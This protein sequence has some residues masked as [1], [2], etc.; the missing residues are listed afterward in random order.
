MPRLS[1]TGRV[2]MGIAGI[3]GSVDSVLIPNSRGG[4]WLDP[5]HIVFIHPSDVG[6]ILYNTI[7]KDRVP[8]SGNAANDLFAGGGQWA[9]WLAGF[10]MYTSTGLVLPNAG[11]LAV[12][13]DGAIGYVPNRNLDNGCHIL[14]VD[15]SQNW[16]LTSVPVAEVQLL[17]SKRAIWRDFN[18]KFSV[19]NLPDVIT[20]AGMKWH[21][22]AVFIDDEWWV[23]YLSAIYGLVL[24]PFNST[25]G[26]II[27]PYSDS[28][29]HPDAVV[30][31]GNTIRVAWSVTNGEG[32]NDYRLKDVDINSLR[33]EIVINVPIAIPPIDKNCY[34]GWFEFKE[35]ISPAPHNCM[36]RVREGGTIKDIDG[37]QFAQWIQSQDGT[38]ESIDNQV[39]NCFFNAVAYW[40]GRNWPRYPSLRMHD[41]LCL[42]AYCFAG[43]PAVIFEFEMRNQISNAIA[44][45]YHRI[46]L[47][48]QAY[49][50]EPPSSLTSDLASLVPVFARL[51]RDYKE[52]APDGMLLLFSDE[53]RKNGLN[54]HQ[55]LLPLYQQL[56]DGILG[57][58]GENHMDNGVVD[59]VLVDPKKYWEVEIIA[60]EDVTNY[61]EVYRRKQHLLTNYGRGSQNRSF[62]SCAPSSRLFMPHAG[63]RSVSPDP[64]IPLEICLGV[65][66]IPEAWE[67]TID[68]VENFPGTDTPKAWLW[69]NPLGPAYVP[70]VADDV[71]VPGDFYVE[72][73]AYDTIV[74]RSDPR[75]ML[76]RFDVTSPLPV[77]TI[78]LELLDDGEPSIEIKFVPENRR[79]GRYCRALA[80]KPVV[81]G[82]WTL[83]VTAVNINGE[84]VSVDG[85]VKVTVLN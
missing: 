80:F 7:T 29:Y 39:A 77:A 62:P 16:Q 3:Q 38:V 28:I 50:Q 72:L 75:G 19:T 47:V 64:N 83:R 48:C 55:Y 41:F 71:P 26:Y 18:F 1:V 15:A 84:S 66:Q 46:V 63:C 85:D 5:V 74:H 30:L 17:G 69:H 49:E 57:A 23:C 14:E 81:N 68:T 36:M 78:D 27:I 67:S 6:I 32:P 45:G 2:A 21:P 52:I 24:H 37:F 20:V 33:S 82:I 31:N 56:F 43:Q 42:Q 58:P 61:V 10:G 79:D 8:L 73:I 12:G 9:A 35:P 22:H 44:A 4:H 76:I 59:G 65:K 60:G 25:V 34:M 13:P 51:A 70:Y 53:G 11:L 40:D 54:D